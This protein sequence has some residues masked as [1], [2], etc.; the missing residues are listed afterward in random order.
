M[1]VMIAPVAGSGS[2]PAWMQR[3][4]KRASGVSFTPAIVAGRAAARPCAAARRASLISCGPTAR[5]R[6]S[7]M[8]SRREAPPTGRASRLPAPP[9]LFRP[10]HR[11]APEPGLLALRRLLLHAWPGRA[12]FG[13]LPLR[14]LVL[15]AEWTCGR[16]ASSPASSGS[17]PAW[18]SSSAA[19]SWPGGSSS[20]AAARLLW[21]V[22][23]RLVVSYL[24]IGV[25]PA[26]LI[27]AFFL[28][29][30]ALLVVS[31]SA[32]LFMTSVNG[33][34]GRGAGRSPGPRP[35]TWSAPRGMARSRPCSIATSA[36]DQAHFRGLSLG[37]GAAP[38]R[39]RR[40]ADDRGRRRC[41]HGRRSCA[42]GR[43][44]TW[45][46]PDRIPAW[47]RAR[48]HPRCCSA[49]AAPA[50][51][52]SSWWRG[53][54]RAAGRRSGASSP[55]SRSTK[56]VW[57]AIEETTGIQMVEL[58]RGHGAADRASSPSRARR[59]RDR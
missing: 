2:W 34:D 4:G 43:G 27:G 29:G 7:S 38:G 13:G 54:W 3:V 35:R 20:A 16:A 33:V 44:R 52:R 59:R 12:L 10:A 17:R 42:P 51:S 25:V 6:R 57:T 15:I 26:L 5:R 41:G 56:P 53:R 19:P 48:R 11:D 18:P 45:R 9:P 31:V 23:E 37:A 36:R 28:F 40:T 39:R 50:T 14:L 8:S 47:H 22:R 46:R 58:T 49:M 30:I 32:Y 1:G 24:F 55:T 21:R